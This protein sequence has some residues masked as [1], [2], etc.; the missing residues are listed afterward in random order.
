MGSQQ[1]AE[2]VHAHLAKPVRGL[3]LDEMGLRSAACVVDQDVEAAEGLLGAAEREG[4]LLLDADVGA[5]EERP[6]SARFDALDRLGSAALVDVRDGDCGALARKA[7]RDR[8]AD[9]RT[10]TGH[11]RRPA[12]KVHTR[13]RRGSTDR[14]RRGRSP[15]SGVAGRCRPAGRAR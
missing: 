11:V 12:R 4:H 2:Q 9:A 10:R 14:G 15:R 5:Q 3:G 13:I 8:A 1:H 7:E 6:A